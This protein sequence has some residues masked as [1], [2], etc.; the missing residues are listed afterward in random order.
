MKKPDIQGLQTTKAQ[1]SRIP[2]RL[3]SVF[4]IRSL[5]GIII[6]L[7]TSEVSIF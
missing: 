4:E 3:I 6:K 2:H 5:D 7:A 1:I